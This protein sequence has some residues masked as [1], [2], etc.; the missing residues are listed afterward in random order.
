MNY[1]GQIN[2]NLWNTESSTD[3]LTLLYY[4]PHCS[5]YT[6]NINNSKLQQCKNIKTTF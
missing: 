2:G 4:N 3:V 1:T 6:E 5:A